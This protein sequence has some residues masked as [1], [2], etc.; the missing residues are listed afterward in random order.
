MKIV[1]EGFR[2]MIP[3]VTDH[4]L[5][6]QSGS[7]VVNA[8]LSK[9]D[10][11]AWRRPL[12]TQ[13]LTEATLKTI[14]QYTENDNLNWVAFEEDVNWFNSP[15]TGESYERVYYSGLSEPRVFANDLASSPFDQTSDY[16]KLGV[17]APAAA[18]TIG[19]Y[20]GSGANYRAYVYTYVNAYGEEGP[21]SAVDSISDYDTGN[22]DIDGITA[23]PATRQI[24]K[25]YLY[26]TSSSGSGVATFRFVLQATWFSA[27]ASY[28]AGADY[29]IY[30]N[31]VYLC[32][33]NHS[34]AWNGGNF[35][36]GENVTDANLSTVTLPSQYWDPPPAALKGLVILPNGVAAG[37]TGND[38][39]LSE[40]YQ[41]HAFPESYIV[42]ISQTI[43]GL[44]TF[45]NNIVVVT[46]GK[47]F[48]ISGENPAQ[49]S[50]RE[51]KGFYPGLS[52]QS[53]VSSEYGVQYVCREGIVRVNDAGV[54]IDTAQFMDPTDW[55]TYYAASVRGVVYSGKYFAFYQDADTVFHG[56]IIDYAAGGVVELSFEIYCG[57]VSESDGQL[58]IGVNDEYDESD[59]PDAKPLC[60]KEWEGDAYNYMYAKFKSK[61]FVLS[62][63][64]NF[65][66]A[67]IIYD[68]EFY[69]DVVQAIA[70]DDVLEDLNATIFAGDIM[71]A[72]NDDPVNELSVNGDLLYDLSGASINPSIVFRV[73]EGGNL[74]FTKTISDNKIFKLNSGYKSKKYKFE[75]EGNIPIQRLDVATSSEEIARG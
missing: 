49:V 2:E 14:M 1:I 59:P 73:Y 16:Y 48:I 47:P 51:L 66:C 13:A 22:V 6:I 28:T 21:P 63:P 41:V 19:S 15:L 29:V 7:Q 9:G 17:P 34:G 58:Y 43:I 37:F 11:R 67:R 40:P 50:S 60:I 71:G 44:G 74:K 70:D 27:A 8:K 62:A 57:Y 20:T 42:S 55:E 72:V 52:K 56:L 5:P 33:I 25:I 24:D 10:F 61:R 64:V 69:D 18:P 45:G 31:D 36:S 26:R 35:T 46:N 4:L 68:Q 65:A 3:R 23:A 30:G 53:I 75:I 38:V 54:T 32:T 12:K 39:Y